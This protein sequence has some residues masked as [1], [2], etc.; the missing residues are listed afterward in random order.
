VGKKY[1]LPIAY[2]AQADKDSWEKVKVFLREVFTP[3]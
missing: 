1:N 3:K 2:N